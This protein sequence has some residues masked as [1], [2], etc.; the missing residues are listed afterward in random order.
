[1]ECTING[2]VIGQYRSEKNG[3]EYITFAESDGGQVKIVFPGQTE[4]QPLQTVNMR[5]KLKPG[6]SNTGGVFL[7]FLEGQ[8]IK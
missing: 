8:H 1:M 7:A 4:F 2:V 5:M 6:L 3:K